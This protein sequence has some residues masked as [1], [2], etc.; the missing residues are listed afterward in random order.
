MGLSKLDAASERFI[1]KD[2]SDNERTMGQLPV[3]LPSPGLRGHG[4]VLDQRWVERRLII[5]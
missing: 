2:V 1:D 4:D 5:P 3:V